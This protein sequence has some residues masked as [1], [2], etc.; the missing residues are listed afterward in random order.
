MIHRAWKTRIRIPAIMATSSTL[1]EHR[2][3]TL[4]YVTFTFRIF[5]RITLITWMG[6]MVMILMM[7]RVRGLLL[8]QFNAVLTL[9]LMALQSW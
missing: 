9:R 7:E 4:Q 3:Q 1:G 2:H 6:V 5:W 8:P